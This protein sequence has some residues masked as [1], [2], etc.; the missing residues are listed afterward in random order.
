MI[1]TLYRCADLFPFTNKILSATTG[2]RL[3]CRPSDSYLFKNSVRDYQ[4]RP[5]DRCH[6][7]VMASQILVS[8]NLERI[9]AFNEAGRML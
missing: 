2:I 8:G 3:I 7:T 1:A 4:Q 9:I 5:K 6:R